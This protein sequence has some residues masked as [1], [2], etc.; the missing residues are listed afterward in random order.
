MRATISSRSFNS[1]S[2]FLPFADMELS[3]CLL[4]FALFGAGAQFSA[5]EPDRELVAD[6]DVAGVDHGTAVAGIDH[7]R[8]AAIEASKRRDSVELGGERAQ[9]PASVL[10]RGDATALE[11]LRRALRR[12]AHARRLR[13]HRVRE[14]SIKLA[15]ADAALAGDGGWRAQA[16]RKLAGLAPG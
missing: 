14:F 10:Q 16:A 1:S 3:A 5:L 15:R 8:V 11:R 9:A 12:G 13:A 7:Y 6:F 4:G 2:N